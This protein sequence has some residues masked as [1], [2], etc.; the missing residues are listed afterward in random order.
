MHVVRFL[1]IELIWGEGV[2]LPSYFYK[3]KSKPLALIV[4]DPVYRA[5]VKSGD[6]AMSPYIQLNRAC[7]LYSSAA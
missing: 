4:Q 7:Q 6:S 3:T 5:A 2:C 1:A